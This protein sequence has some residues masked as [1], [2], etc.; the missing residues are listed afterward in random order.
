[1]PRTRHLRWGVAALL[2]CSTALNYLDRQTLSVLVGTIQKD[3][4]FDD[5]AYARMTSVFLVAYAVMYAVGGRIMDALGSRR[6]LL[7]F[8][9][10]WSVVNMLHGFARSVLQ[11]SV[12]RVLLGVTEAANIPGGVKAVSEWFPLRERALAVGVFNAGTALG[13]ALAAPVV[14]VIALHFGWRAAF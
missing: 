8:V 1:M 6:G 5:A 2:C 3:L 14:S 13:A 9:S 11:L 7:V 10:A 4:G 12:F